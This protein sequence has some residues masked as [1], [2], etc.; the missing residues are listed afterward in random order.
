MST[1]LLPESMYQSYSSTSLWAAMAHLTPSSLDVFFDLNGG[2]DKLSDKIAR[3]VDETHDLLSNALLIMCMSFTDHQVVPGRVVGLGQ[4]GGHRL[5]PGQQHGRGVDPSQPQTQTMPRSAKLVL[6]NMMM[7][8]TKRPLI[9]LTK[10]ADMYTPHTYMY[11]LH[12]S[13]AEAE[14]LGHT[15][16][17]FLI[18]RNFFCDV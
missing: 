4:P 18:S 3:K 9:L 6:R 15:L 7:M 13:S 16:K 8:I 10:R 1:D 2:F 11:S 14:R 17:L 12:H 5:L